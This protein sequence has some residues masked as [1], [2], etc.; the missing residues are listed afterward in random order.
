MRAGMQGVECS[1]CVFFPSLPNPKSASCRG[2]CT[3]TKRVGKGSADYIQA[4]LYK[5]EECKK[6]AEELGKKEK[7]LDVL[8]NN[9]GS[10]WGA[11]YDEFPESA[12]R[13]SHSLLTLASRWSIL[14]L[15]SEDNTNISNLVDQS[16]HTEPHPRI[17]PDASPHTSPRSRRIPTL[18][19][20]HNQHRFRR[21]SPRSFT[22]DLLLLRLQSRLAPALSRPRQPS[23]EAKHHI[24]HP[25]LRT[26]PKQD[27]EG[28]TRELWGYD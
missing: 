24:E 19:L 11:P 17:H 13:D 20:P 18:P 1:G 14:L 10:N 15:N 25:C 2:T 21:R 16:S 12:V 5:V 8:V 26:F 23:R 4:D 9:S 3:K 6:I 22:R 27:D 7:Q 28:D